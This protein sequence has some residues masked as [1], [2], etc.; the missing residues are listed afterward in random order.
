MY[1][2]VY[3]LKYQLPHTV[4]WYMFW[5]KTKR[6]ASFYGIFSERGSGAAAL[7]HGSAMGT[8][9]ENQVQELSVRLQQLGVAFQA[10]QEDNRRLQEQVNLSGGET[11]VTPLIQSK[12]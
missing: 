8:P 10:S 2:Y 9:L 3:L 11:A 12:H 4:T 1:L 6:R 5:L 7:V